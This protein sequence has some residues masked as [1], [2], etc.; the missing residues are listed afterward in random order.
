VV[1]RAVEH[2]EIV[3]NREAEPAKLQAASG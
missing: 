1:A 2:V 3:T